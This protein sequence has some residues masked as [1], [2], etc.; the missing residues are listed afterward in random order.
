MS[1]NAQSKR[2]STIHYY[3]FL[4]DCTF[5]NLNAKEFIYG[6]L[7][8]IMRGVL[9]TELLFKSSPEKVEDLHPVVDGVKN[10]L[11]LI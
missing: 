11:L 4:G 5:T 2:T 10:L 7:H 3:K 6:Q 9:K 1:E 8:R